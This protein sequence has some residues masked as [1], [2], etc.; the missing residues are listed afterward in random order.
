ML[1][2]GVARVREYG[3]GFFGPFEMPRS[4][5]LLRYVYARWKYERK[6]EIAVT[7]RGILKRDKFTCAYCGKDTAS[8]I[9]HIL[10]RSRGGEDSWDNLV[11]ACLKCNNVKDDRTPKEAGMR[12]LFEPRIPTFAEVYAWGKK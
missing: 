8:T 11:A 3:E 2:R 12:L 7:R 1:W 6:G 9:D 5:E 4:V 10:P